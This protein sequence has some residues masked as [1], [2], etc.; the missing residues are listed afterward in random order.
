MN[1]SF[2][3]QPVNGVQLYLE[4]LHERTDGDYLIDRFGINLA[5]PFGSTTLPAVHRGMFEL[6]N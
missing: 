4:L 2:L 1:L 6:A 3:F 5:D